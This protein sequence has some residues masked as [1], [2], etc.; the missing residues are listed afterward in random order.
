MFNLLV[1][2]ASKASKVFRLGSLVANEVDATTVHIEVADGT[3]DVIIIG[4]TDTDR[5]LGNAEG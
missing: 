1:E 2:T 3:F 4:A 5:L